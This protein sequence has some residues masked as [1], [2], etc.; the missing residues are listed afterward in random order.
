MTLLISDVLTANSVNT[1]V[2]NQNVALVA[3]VKRLYKLAH[4]REREALAVSREILAKVHVVDVSPH[5][6]EGNSSSRIVSNNLSDHVDVPVS[7]L[8][9]VET[10]GPVRVHGGVA[11]DVSWVIPRSARHARSCP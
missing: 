8:A 1:R 5:D 7:I 10:K 6:F 11:G 3:R 4:L 2:E 9:L